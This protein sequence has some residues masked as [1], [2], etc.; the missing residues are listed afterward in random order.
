MVACITLTS[1]GEWSAEYNNKN[2]L[3]FTFWHHLNRHT[4]CI[5]RHF[6]YRWAG[7]RLVLMMAAGIC[8]GSRAGEAAHGH[9]KPQEPRGA[10]PPLCSLLASLPLSLP[11]ALLK[12]T[13]NTTL[14][15]RQHET[16]PRVCGYFKHSHQSHTFRSAPG[17]QLISHCCSSAAY[18]GK[19]VNA[20]L[21]NASMSSLVWHNNDSVK[22]H[23]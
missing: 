2:M 3:S 9:P 19:L 21:I 6:V 23:K 12:G 5:K 10:L 7:G 13:P 15:S 4:Y 20:K 14:Q 16:E 22:W 18:R 11:H 17:Q 1:A 8:T